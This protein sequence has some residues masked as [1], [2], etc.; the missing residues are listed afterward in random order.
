LATVTLH[1][2]I[3][4]GSVASV[5]ATDFKCIIC[6]EFPFYKHLKANALPSFFEKKNKIKYERQ[7]NPKP[8]QKGK[9]KAQIELH[10]WT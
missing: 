8:H 3:F 6:A 4:A 9:K 7:K 1:T 2:C 5:E 10:C